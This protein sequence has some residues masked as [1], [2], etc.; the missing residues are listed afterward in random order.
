MLT[1]EGVDSYWIAGIV[2]WAHK[3]TFERLESLMTVIFLFTV[4]AENVSQWNS[5]PK[6]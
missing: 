5:D 1:G 3:F 6:S 2:F 4:T